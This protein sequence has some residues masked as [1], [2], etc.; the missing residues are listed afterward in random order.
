[1]GNLFNSK[2]LILI[3]LPS[4]L[5]IFIGYQAAKE[6]EPTSC[7]PTGFPARCYQV[8]QKI[9]EA[10]WTKSGESC[11]EFIQKLTLPPGRLIGPII[12]KCQLTALDNAF[13]H[14]R[15]ATVE[16]KEMV[17]DLEDWKRRNDF[18]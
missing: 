4:L 16:C 14:S 15:K 5:L 3:S 11:K 7:A 13:S 10:L 17:V 12:F 2:N 1:M 18:K 6:A 8:P 9:C